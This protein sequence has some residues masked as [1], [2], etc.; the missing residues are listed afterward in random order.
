MSLNYF[1]Q[2]GNFCDDERLYVFD[3]SEWTEEDW[4]DIEEAGDYTRAQVAQ[5]IAMRYLEEDN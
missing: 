1:A 3:T 5:D 2:D 4:M